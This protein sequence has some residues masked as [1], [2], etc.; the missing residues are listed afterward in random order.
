MRFW[1]VALPTQSIRTRAFAASLVIAL[2]L[3]TQ[4]HGLADVA[5]KRVMMLH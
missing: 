5:P 2:L 1:L 4:T 3:A